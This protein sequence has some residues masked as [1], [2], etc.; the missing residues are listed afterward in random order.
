MSFVASN[1]KVLME[2]RKMNTE[3]RNFLILS[4][5]NGVILAFCELFYNL[6][7]IS[8]PQNLTD[9][10]TLSL[11]KKNYRQLGILISPS[12]SIKLKRKILIE[13]RALQNL[14]LYQCLGGYH[15]HNNNNN[16]NSNN[17][18]NNSNNDNNNNN[19]SSNSNENN[20]DNNDN[21]NDDN[22]NNDSVS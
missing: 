9:G 11:I 8:T 15:Y 19:N 4:C 2:M 5:A 12:N 13:D 18:N 22:L 6:L 20:N 7:K 1:V 14:A 16:N 10:A 21:N 17:N 3:K